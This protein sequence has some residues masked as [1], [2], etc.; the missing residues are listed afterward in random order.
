MD[1]RPEKGD[2]KRQKG[3]RR[4][5]KGAGGMQKPK[6][7]RR[8]EKGYIR[9]PDMRRHGSLASYPENLSLLVLI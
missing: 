4:L 7:D 9:N 3:D 5:E 1:R 6:V 2:R 8:Y